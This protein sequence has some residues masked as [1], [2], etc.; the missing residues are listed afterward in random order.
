MTLALMIAHGVNSSGIREILA[1][2]PMFDESEDSWPAFFQK[3]K[4]RGLRRVNLCISDAR[5]GIKAAVKKELLGASWQRCKAHFMRNIITKVPH[6]EKRRFAA[7]LKQIW[8]QPIG[9]APDGQRLS[10]FRNTANVFQTPHA[11]SRKGLR[12]RCSSMLLPRSI[13]RR[14]LRRTCPSAR[15]GRSSAAAAWLG[16]SPPSSPGFDWLPVISWSTQ[17]TGPP[18]G[19][20]SNGRRSRKP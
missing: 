12:T 3:L 4:K 8:L 6:K 7:H 10:W 11:V 17:K 13:P 18:I 9:R 5:S 16:S 15:S 14:S 20:I 1:V 19:A 2:E